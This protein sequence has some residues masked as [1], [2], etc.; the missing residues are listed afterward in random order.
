MTT[1]R[2]TVEQ[3]AAQ[4]GTNLYDYEITD[5]RVPVRD[6]EALVKLAVRCAAEEA[7]RC[8]EGQIDP[9]WPSDRESDVARGCA[10]AIREHF[11]IPQQD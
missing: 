2:S 4:T 9:E 5:D 10:F 6:L 1:P 8:C 11:D 7:A 3:W